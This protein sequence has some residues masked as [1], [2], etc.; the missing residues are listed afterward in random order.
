[1]NT[2]A[3]AVTSREPMAGSL[4]RKNKPNTYTNV[5]FVSSYEH[6]C[7]VISQ[8]KL[9]ESVYSLSGT[10]PK[11]AQDAVL[12]QKRPRV[13]LH[14]LWKHND[15]TWQSKCLPQAWQALPQGWQL[16]NVTWCYSHTR[17]ATA[18]YRRQGTIIIK[19]E[20]FKQA[21]TN[22]GRNLNV[23]TMIE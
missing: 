15:R 18:V 10:G 7:S 2:N 1:M 23:H 8:N 11:E 3:Y 4:G 17:C 14:N 21:D 12:V 20:N 6:R 9:R 19:E 5:T 22:H 16:T 13:R